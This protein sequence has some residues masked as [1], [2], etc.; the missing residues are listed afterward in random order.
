VNPTTGAAIPGTVIGEYDGT[1]WIISVNPGYPQG[2]ISPPQLVIEIGNRQ[3]PIT[4]VPN[5]VAFDPIANS[6]VLQVQMSGKIPHSRG[7]II[8][9]ANPDPTQSPSTPG[10]PGPQPGFNYKSPRYAPV[11]KYVE[12]LK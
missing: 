6:A 2:Q 10:N 4:V 12:Q 3:E 11:V 7:A 8:R 9:L 5:G 1:P